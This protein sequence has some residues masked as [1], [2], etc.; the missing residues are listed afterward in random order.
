VADSSNQSFGFFSRT[1]TVTRLGPNLDINVLPTPTGYDKHWLPS[2]YIELNEEW[3]PQPSE[4]RVGEPITRTLT[5][6]A[7]GLVEEQLPDINSRYPASLKTYPE[8]P[9]SATVERDDSLIAQRVERIAIIPSEPGDIT[10]PEVRVP[11]FNVTTRTTEYATLPSRTV[12]I[13]PAT[14]QSGILPTLPIEQPVNET[15]PSSSSEVVTITEKSFWS[16]SSWILLA[17]W[18]LTLLWAL[19]R[20]KAPRIAH[21]E[22]QPSSNANTWDQLSA[23]IKTNNPG[24]IQPALSSWLAT[25]CNRPNATL[26]QCQRIL[27]NSALDAAI[28]DMLQ[29]RYGKENQPWKADVLLQIIKQL[30]NDKLKKSVSS[31]TE[32]KPLY[33][34]T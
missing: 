23:A 25:L 12:T 22:I 21:S 7:V 13:Q 16:L 32:L 14:S 4:Y 20:N 6:T 5:L 28:K 31:G 18:L 26:N 19:R 24:D 2:N 3:Q 10:L 34:S 29:A 17:L 15:V 11:W 9:T 1:K 27:S 30:K 33:P 8:Q